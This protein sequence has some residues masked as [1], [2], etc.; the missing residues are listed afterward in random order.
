[1]CDL[2][3]ASRR[4]PALDT[5]AAATAVHT[6]H[7]AS[8]AMSRVGGGLIGFSNAPARLVPAPGEWAPS[9]IVDLDPY[10]H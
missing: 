8:A 4:H 10:I 2:L 5:P 6:N 7:A 1:M 9:A 3:L